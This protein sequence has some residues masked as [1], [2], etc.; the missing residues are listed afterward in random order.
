[1]NVS[2]KTVKIW[3]KNL[4]QGYRFFE[5]H[6]ATQMTPRTMKEAYGYTRYNEIKTNEF[7]MNE[8]TKAYITALII[9]AVA[10]VVS[11]WH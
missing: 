11:L 6:N 4:K 10:L 2:N 7:N 9:V 5:P 1:M 8:T 3:R